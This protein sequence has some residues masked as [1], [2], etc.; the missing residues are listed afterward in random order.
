MTHIC[1]SKLIIFCSDNGLS[2]G[3]RQ[4]VIWT[5]AEILLIGPLRTI[6]IHIFSFKNMYLKMLSG[7]WQ[8]SCPGLNVLMYLRM[9]VSCCCLMFITVGSQ[10]R[11]G[12]WQKLAGPYLVGCWKV[13]LASEYLVITGGNKRF[14]Q[15]WILLSKLVVNPDYP[16]HGT[17]F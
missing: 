13:K 4:A 8:P 1:V 5:N 17:L 10:F 15:W 14:H 12:C 16:C 11:C 6:K 3:R 7:N 2:P 9:S